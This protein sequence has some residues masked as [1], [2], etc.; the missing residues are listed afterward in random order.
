[1][2]I[3]PLFTWLR[4]HRAPFARTAAAL[5]SALLCVAAQ[6]GLG[7]IAWLGWLCFI[8][9]L[10]VAQRVGVG[11]GAWL[12]LL[13]GIGFS[14]IGKWATM[15]S[16]VV[17]AEL[18]LWGEILAH[19]AIFLPMALPFVALGLTLPWLL[20]RSAAPV[21][22]VQ[23]A[24]LFAIVSQLS[25]LLPPYTVVTLASHAV[26]FIQIADLGGLP[27]VIFVF[28]LL[29]LL[30]ALALQQAWQRRYPALLR[31]M[32]LWVGLL[33]LVLAY[34][35]YRLVEYHTLAAANDGSRLRVLAVQSD[36][37]SPGG[38]RLVLRDHRDAPLSPLEL[39]RRGLA[40]HPEAELVVWPEIDN[41]PPRSGADY[42]EVCRRLPPIVATMGTPLLYN[43]FHYPAEGKMRS[44][45]HLLD[46]QGQTVGR[47]QKNHLVPFYETGRELFGAT[48]LVS[49]GSGARALQLAD[50]RR[51]VPAICYDIHDAELIRH[52]VA[53]GG[54][55]ILQMASFTAFGHR[56]QISAWD[57]AIARLRAVETR[58]PL[59]RVAN[60]GHSGLTLASGE[61]DSA[62][63][64][65]PTRRSARLHDAFAPNMQ[66][67]FVYWGIWPVMGLLAL[68][69]LIPL[70]PLRRASKEKLAIQSS[71]VSGQISTTAGNVNPTSGG[72]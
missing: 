11:E 22:M 42:D 23:G 62:G 58:R 40:R 25:T 12:G 43:C 69:L 46:A 57:M 63:F 8:P 65:P 35:H 34:G 19:L 59:L 6:P 60:R 3:V 28:I 61:E 33:T 41:G 71:P 39:T 30:A 31:S 66:S 52:G 18:P 47:Y 32:A 55:F 54:Q 1:M 27:L 26:V 20:R 53:Q 51:L 15:H 45:A 50:G 36:V 9:W 48:T 29:Q 14:L 10:L 5:L 64:S 68:L 4:R 70:W 21:A 49:S 44:E 17:A 67:P 38:A 56:P 7:E 16:V 72:R 24:A 13:V 37:P 2:P